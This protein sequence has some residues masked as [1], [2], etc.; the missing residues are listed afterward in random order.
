VG[1]PLPPIVSADNLAIR[2][3]RDMAL[4]TSTMPASARIAG[5]SLLGLGRAIPVGDVN[6]ASARAYAAVRVSL[7][8]GKL[9]QQCP[10]RLAPAEQVL[11]QCGQTRVAGSAPR[12]SIAT[13]RDQAKSSADFS[14]GLP[15]AVTVPG[16][17]AISSPTATTRPRSWDTSALENLSM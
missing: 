11:L 10:H 7:A 4:P 9:V 17:L 3:C 14:G 5:H 1:G 13:T 15:P 16:A 8:V 2:G 12:S 6:A